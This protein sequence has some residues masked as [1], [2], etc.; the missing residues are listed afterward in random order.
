MLS[1]CWTN[2]GRRMDMLDVWRGPRG[3]GRER[4]MAQRASAHSSKLPKKRATQTGGP[5]KLVASAQK[6]NNNVHFNKYQM[7]E[8]IIQIQKI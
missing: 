8:H 4:A 6:R 5:A 1:Q 3:P 7:K 2:V